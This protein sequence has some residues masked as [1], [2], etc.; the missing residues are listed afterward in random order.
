MNKKVVLITGASSGIGKA[1][2]EKFLEKGYIVY[3]AARNVNNMLDLE[4]L[5][6]KIIKLDI[7]KFEEI[8][9]SVEQ[10]ISEQGRIDILFNNAGF[11][12]IWQYRRG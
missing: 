12:L 4:K 7:S 5:G 9:K 3:G 8:E 1:S 10:I 11:G 2:A 6:A